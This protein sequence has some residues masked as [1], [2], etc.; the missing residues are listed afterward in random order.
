MP[1]NFASVISTVAL[2]EDD[3]A[4]WVNLFSRFVS[5]HFSSP[6]PVPRTTRLCQKLLLFQHRSKTLC[7]YPA[8]QYI[9]YD[10]RLDWV[11]VHRL[12]S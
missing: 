5:H 3:Y 1:N 11:P 10:Q 2:F 9:V 7:Y 12:S 4:G 6:T 8:A